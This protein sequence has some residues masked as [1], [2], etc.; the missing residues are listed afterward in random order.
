MRGRKIRNDPYVFL[1]GFLR[2]PVEGSAATSRPPLAYGKPVRTPG[3]SGSAVCR[4]KVTTGSSGGPNHV[5][6]S[7]GKSGDA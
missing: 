7:A 4:K 6:N 3:Y 2:V 1:R 5:V